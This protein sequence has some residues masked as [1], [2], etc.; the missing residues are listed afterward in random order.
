MPLEPS[1]KIATEP[2]NKIWASKLK[3]TNPY[4]RALHTRIWRKHQDAL[5]A[6]VGKRGSGKSWLSLGRAENLDPTFKDAVLNDPSSRIC[7]TA[8]GYAEFFSKGKVGNA[9]IFDEAGTGIDHRKFWKVENDICRMLSQ[10]QRHKRFYVFFTVPHI[11]YI[12]SDLRNLFHSYIHVVGFDKEKKLTH[13][14]PMFKHVD[15]I[16][17]FSITQYFTAKIADPRTGKKHFYSFRKGF[18]FK[19]P[20]DDLANAYEDYANEWKEKFEAEQTKKIKQEEEEESHKEFDKE[21]LQA[22]A[23]KVWS[24]SQE[25]SKNKG[26]WDEDYIAMDFNLGRTYARRIAKLLARMER[27]AVSEY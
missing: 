25:Y 26:G 23:D 17:D 19:A 1:L 18:L 7:F 22:I 5:V 8:Q 9:F 2:S 20:S 10:V 15:P 4:E 21:E 13:A 3:L 27:T 11:K 24:K 12:D 6:T 16:S 14:Y